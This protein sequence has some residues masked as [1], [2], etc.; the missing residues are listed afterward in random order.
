MPRV[1]VIGGIHHLIACDASKNM[2]EPRN[3]NDEILSDPMIDFAVTT[4]VPILSSDENTSEDIQMLIFSVLG[5]TEFNEEN[6]KGFTQVQRRRNKYTNSAA[7]EEAQLFYHVGYNSH[8]MITRSHSN[9][10]QNVD[11]Y[12]MYPVDQRF[13]SPPKLAVA[14]KRFKNSHPEAKTYQPYLQKAIKVS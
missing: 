6:N 14:L 9:R 4:P 12:F 5:H 7:T 11:D 8:P 3:G 1:V 10:P 2:S 13:D